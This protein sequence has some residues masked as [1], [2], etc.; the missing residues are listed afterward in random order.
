MIGAVASQREAVG[1]TFAAVLNC[2]ELTRSRSCVF[3]C[4]S[5]HNLR[6]YNLSKLD[7][8]SIGVY[9]LY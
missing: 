1:F 8:F 9:F 5:S 3:V 6:T 4:I 2:V 7:K